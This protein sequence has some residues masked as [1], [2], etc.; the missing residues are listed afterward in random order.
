LMSTLRSCKPT[1]SVP[2]AIKAVARLAKTLILGVRR[3]GADQAMRYGVA[4]AVA[5]LI[6]ALGVL[7]V[8]HTQRSIEQRFRQGLRE[9]RINGKLP[10]GID[11][12][13]ANP[14][15][16]GITLSAA[17]M[18]RMEIANLFIAW[19]SFSSRWFLS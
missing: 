5:V 4:L 8:W 7:F 14:G 1:A 6:I 2:A 9:A 3:E 15:D 16:F 18:R 11:P 17:E 12:E 13:Q 10:P 19:R